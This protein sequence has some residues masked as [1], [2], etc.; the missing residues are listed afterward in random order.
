MPSSVLT[1]S[2]SVPRGRYEVRVHCFLGKDFPALDNNGALDPYMTANFAGARAVRAGAI[3]KAEKHKTSTINETAFPD[4]FETLC[5]QVRHLHI[6]LRRRPSLTFSHLLS[7]SRPETLCMQTWLP[8]LDHLAAPPADGD[9]TLRGALLAPEL[10]LSVWDEDTNILESVS[11]QNPDDLV[12]VARVSL[13]PWLRQVR[14]LPT[15]PSS[16]DHRSPSHRA[17][18]AVALPGGGASGGGDAHCT[19]PLRACARFGWPRRRL[20]LSRRRGGK[21]PSGI[22]ARAQAVGGPLAVAIVSME[23]RERHVRPSARSAHISILAQP[24]LTFSPSDAEQHVRPADDEC[25]A[26]PSSPPLVPRGR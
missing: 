24:S 23:R 26:H 4:W 18:R 8:P 9:R 21:R 7:P 20:R 2:S 22:R 13:E 19:C 3:R 11:G 14:H 12:G 10:V 16:R 6:S 1:L 5:I 25:R 17:S 15:S